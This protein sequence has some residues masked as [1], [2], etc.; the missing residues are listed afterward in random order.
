MEYNNKQQIEEALKNVIQTDLEKSKEKLNTIVSLL[1]SEFK[2]L[3]EEAFLCKRVPKE[4]MLSSIFFT[5]STSVGLTFYLKGLGYKNYGNCYFTIVGSRGDAKSEAIK[6]ATNPIKE[7]DDV[8]YEDYLDELRV[9]EGDEKSVIRKQNLI[10]NASIEAAHKV[11]A[12]NPN[13][14]GIAI[15]E[16]YGLIEKM[17]NPNSRDGVA[18]RNFFLEGYTNGCLDVSRKTTQSFRIKSTYVTLIGGLQYQFLPKLFANGNLESGFIDRQFFT[19][20]ITHNNTLVVEG[21]ANSSLVS[22]GASIK[23]ILAYKRQSEN[24]EETKKQFEIVMSKSAELLLFEYTQDLINRQ[25]EAEPVIKEYMSKMQISVQKLCVIIF[26][27]LNA[28]GSTFASVLTDEVVELAIEC[29]EFYFLNFQLIVK[30]GF[31]EAEPSV[32]QIIKLAKKNEASQKAVA[33]ITGLHK[34][35]ISKKWAKV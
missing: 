34:G 1:P 27:M 18:W 10:Q 8:E 15:D 13:A 6:I 33:E 11:H 31:R 32:E 24:P 25:G 28:S 35:T 5:V 19:P 23:N 26:M 9:S 14:V 7:I 16:I 20:K 17:A 3:I 21:I 30:E 2:G 22:Y 29:N 12:D 4:Y